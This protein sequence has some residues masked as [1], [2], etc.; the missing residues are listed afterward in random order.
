MGNESDHDLIVRI[1][2]RVGAMHKRLEDGD[3]RFDDHS[4]RL[5]ILENWRSWLAGG[6]VFL[7][8]GVTVAFKVLG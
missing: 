5:R 6:F 1:D 2:E 4:K 3:D 8:V 7:S